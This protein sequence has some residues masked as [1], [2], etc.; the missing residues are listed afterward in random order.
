MAHRFVTPVKE[1]ADYT[2]CGVGFKYIDLAEEE[3]SK[4]IREVCKYEVVQTETEHYSHDEYGDYDYVTEVNRFNLAEMRSLSE[5]I[6]ARDQAAGDIIVE[7]GEL[8]GI[9]FFTGFTDYRNLEELGIIPIEH[10]ESRANL[11]KYVS[12]D[13]SIF[14]LQTT[15]SQASSS[16]EAQWSE[17]GRSTTSYKT[18]YYLEKK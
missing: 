15:E 12:V 2:A 17:S 3:A 5:K 10:L 4:I 8:V 16:T 7:N 1:G 6:W 11:T 9:A 13:V 14:R 18:N